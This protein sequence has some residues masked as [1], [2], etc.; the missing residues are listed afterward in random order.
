LEYTFDEVPINL[1]LDVRPAF[2]LV[3]HTGFWADVALSVRYVF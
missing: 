1:G 3:G 2:N